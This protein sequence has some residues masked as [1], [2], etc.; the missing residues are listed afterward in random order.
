MDYTPRSPVTIKTQHL[1]MRQ[2]RTIFCENLLSCP[3]ASLCYD[4][5]LFNIPS[6]PNFILQ[7]GSTTLLERGKNS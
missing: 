6:S 2:K 1:Q 4:M 5:S 7:K 3:P